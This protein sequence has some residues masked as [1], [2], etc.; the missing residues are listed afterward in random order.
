MIEKCAE[1]YSKAQHTILNAET[2]ILRNDGRIVVEVTLVGD[3]V[4]DC[5][6]RVN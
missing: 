6:K 3:K 2:A 5:R 1:R 4:R